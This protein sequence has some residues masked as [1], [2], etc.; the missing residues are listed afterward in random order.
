M[1]VRATFLFCFS[2]SSEEIKALQKEIDELRKENEVAIQA[3]DQ[4]LVHHLLIC[5]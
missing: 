1:C 3:K 4:E 5:H 2:D